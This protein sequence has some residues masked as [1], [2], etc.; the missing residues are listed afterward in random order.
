MSNSYTITRGEYIGDHNMPV[1]SMDLDHDLT[2]IKRYHKD[3]VERC[4]ESDVRFDPVGF[5]YRDCV[6]VLKRSWHPSIFTIDTDLDEK[7]VRYMINE[8]R[9]TLNVEVELNKVIIGFKD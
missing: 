9:K 6:L 2:I 1:P 7:M 4:R 8:F 5:D 3:G